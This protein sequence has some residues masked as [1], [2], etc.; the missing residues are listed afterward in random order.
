MTMIVINVNTVI[1]SRLVEKQTIFLL[2]HV[3][4]WRSSYVE[5]TSYFMLCPEILIKSAY[6]NSTIYDSYE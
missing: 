6:K 5:L 4:Y 2:A 3:G 1:Y